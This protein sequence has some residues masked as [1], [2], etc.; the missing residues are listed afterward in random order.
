[1]MTVDGREAAVCL[2]DPL[3]IG[4]VFI[5][6]IQIHQNIYW[7]LFQTQRIQRGEDRHSL[8]SP[9]AHILLREADSEHQINRII[10]DHNK[11]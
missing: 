5:H 2:W 7:E 3:Q 9:G 1:M 10:S 11:R 8:H 4:S 6:F